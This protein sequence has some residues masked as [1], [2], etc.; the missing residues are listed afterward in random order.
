MFARALPAVLPRSDED[1][2]VMDIKGFTYGYSGRR[3]DF[4][5]PKAVRS[6]ELLYDI[7]INW[8]CLAV[9]NHQKNF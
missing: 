1:G 5:S 2:G 3:G 7:G 4:R 9:V 6:Q 8:L